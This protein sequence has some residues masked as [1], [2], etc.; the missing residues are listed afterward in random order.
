M[1]GGVINLYIKRSDFYW[2]TINDEIIDTRQLLLLNL[3]PVAPLEKCD[4][5]FL[6]AA[7]LS[8]VRISFV[9]AIVHK[10][11]TFSLDVLL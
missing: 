3:G 6:L 4:V 2:P 8:E 7:S 9:V 11:L 5:A 10:I 1:C